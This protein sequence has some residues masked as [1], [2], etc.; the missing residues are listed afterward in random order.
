MILP[1]KGYS[2]KLDISFDMM[3]A[4]LCKQ[5]VRGQMSAVTTSMAERK[6]MIRVK[7]MARRILIGSVA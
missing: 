5:G 1:N 6:M 2:A 4:V 7:M 3:L